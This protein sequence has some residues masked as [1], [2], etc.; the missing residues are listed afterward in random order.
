MPPHLGR[1]PGEFLVPANEFFDYESHRDLLKTAA[2][3][4]VVV[5]CIG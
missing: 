5:A 2:A 4:V 3:A 1:P